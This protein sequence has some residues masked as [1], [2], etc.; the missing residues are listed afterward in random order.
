MFIELTDIGLSYEEKTDEYRVD[1][2]SPD[3]GKKLLFNTD[4]I[5]FIKPYTTLDGVTC[6]EIFYHD[7]SY[8]VMDSYEKVK[9]LIL[10][11]KKDVETKC[12]PISTDAYMKFYSKMKAAM[13]ND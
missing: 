8:Y 10:G 7:S 6:T 13:N 5:I 9:S 3:H 1:A 4:Q 12:D 11:T 2:T